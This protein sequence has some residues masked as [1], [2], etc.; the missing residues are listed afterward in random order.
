MLTERA[1]G[2]ALYKELF[3]PD[4]QPLL[5]MALR[6]SARAAQENVDE[7]MR[8]F[9][10]EFQARPESSDPVW[11]NS[12]RILSARMGRGRQFVSRIL[13]YSLEDAAPLVRA[14]SELGRLGDTHGL[15]HGFGYLVPFPD[16]TRAVMEYDYYYD[17][18]DAREVRSM[19]RLMEESARLVSSLRSDPGLVCSSDVVLMQ[20]LCR[21]ETYLFGR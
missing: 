1:E 11:L 17:R 13:Y 6:T 3:S 7:D 18:T 9:F 21:P 12:F 14:C 15:R 16:G 4:L 10:A 2:Q 8:G 20:G 19:Q 5:E